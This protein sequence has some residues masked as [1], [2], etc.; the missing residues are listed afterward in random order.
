[1]YAGN[2]GLC[3]KRI[4]PR[5]LSSIMTK[6]LSHRINKIRKKTYQLPLSYPSRSQISFHMAANFG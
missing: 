1:M 4:W 2:I 3:E 5:S 6:S